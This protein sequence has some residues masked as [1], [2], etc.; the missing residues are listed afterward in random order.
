MHS[1]IGLGTG[2]A[3]PRAVSRRNQ[4]WIPLPSVCSSTRI[5]P[6]RALF[7]RSMGQ[8]RLEC[9]TGHPM[10]TG[11]ADRTEDLITGDKTT[12]FK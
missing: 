6:L 2:L 4:R 12:A 7:Q 10:N 11:S 5:K 1:V 9:G 8:Q 3:V